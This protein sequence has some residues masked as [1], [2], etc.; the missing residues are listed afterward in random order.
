[1]IGAPSPHLST[2]HPENAGPARSGE[3]RPAHQPAQCPAPG[4]WA[5]RMVPGSGKQRKR[6]LG[7]DDGGHAAGQGFQGAGDPGGSDMILTK[8]DVRMLFWLNGWGAVTVEQIAAWMGGVLF[9][10][11]ARRVR[12]LCDAGLLRR[13]EVVGLREQPIGLTEA[14]RRVARDPLEPLPGVRLATWHHD[15]TMCSME[16]RILRHYPASVVNPERRIRAN[17]LIAGAPTMHLPDAEVQRAGAPPIGF[18]LELSPKG[19]A[20]IQEIVD[21]Y[22]TSRR[23]A[24]VVYLVPDQRMARYVRRFTDAHGKL[25]DIRLI[26]VPSAL[27]RPGGAING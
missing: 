22:A 17:R 1:M 25:F 23:Y 8:R 16:A 21:T 11:A 6:R 5:T 14:G 2:K 3:L 13:I 7:G 18:E 15:Q 19:K 26:N 10:T 20:R 9:S 27:D 12:K 4:R 24:S